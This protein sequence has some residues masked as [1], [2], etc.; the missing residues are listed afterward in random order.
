MGED[1]TKVKKNSS[2]KAIKKDKKITVANCYRYEQRLEEYLIEALRLQK[3]EEKNSKEPGSKVSNKHE[4]EKLKNQ[5]DKVDVLNKIIFP[6]MANLIYLFEFMNKHPEV[7]KILNKDIDELLGL[8]GLH[9]KTGNAN[10]RKKYYAFQRMMLSLISYQNKNTRLAILNIIGLE[11]IQ[12]LINL[13]TEKE[14]QIANLIIIPDVGRALGW[15]RRFTSG[16]T[17]N[18]VR[19]HRP[20]TF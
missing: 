15:I 17:L 1:F 9:W 14:P 11:I 13:G 5:N 4:S 3:A 19:A 20:I 6:S 7:D 16:I 18:N 2:K 8:K 10:E 12:Q